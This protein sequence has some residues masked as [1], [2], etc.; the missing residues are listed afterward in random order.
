MTASCDQWRSVSRVIAIAVVVSLLMRCGDASDAKTSKNK[1]KS[2]VAVATAVPATPTATVSPIKEGLYRRI[3]VVGASASAGFGIFIK[4]DRTL[5]TDSQRT[6]TA[7]Q[8]PA[9][10]GPAPIGLNLAEILR[11]AVPPVDS[12]NPTV[13]CVTLNYSSGFFFLAPGS[14]GRSQIGRVL[15]LKPTLMLGLDFLFWY[16]YGNSTA[17][18]PPTAMKTGAE[19]IANLELGLAELDRVVSAG[20]PLV[21]GDISD[22][23]DAIGKMLSKSQVPDAETIAKAN[24]RI[25]AWVRE[26]P[27]VRI[28]SLSQVLKELKAGGTITLAGTAWNPAEFG[29]LL[30]NDQLHPTFAGAV[31]IVAGLIDLAQQNDASTANFFDFNP[32]TIRARVIEM[33]QKKLTRPKNESK[34]KSATEVPTTVP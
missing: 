13:R 15:A 32:H 10:R 16:V 5:Q 3:A 30:Q 17:A 8:K 6:S 4:P 2:N 27:T 23:H 18:D 29:P 14:T 21:I 28:L 26:R 7:S 22:M 31:I 11:C 24:E 1:S 9:P 34:S 25:N 33:E 19:R 12:A 20:V